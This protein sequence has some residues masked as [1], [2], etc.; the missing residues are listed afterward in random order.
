MKVISLL[1]TN[2]K[3]DNRVYRMA[4]TLSQNGF[5]TTVVAWKKGDITE[6]ENFNGVEVE[7]V[8]VFSDRWK[9]LNLIIGAIQYFEFAFRV[10]FIVNMFSFSV[11]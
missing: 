6:K 4:K 11:S 3:N 2:F 7:R 5:R 1:V 9:R 8:I 10:V